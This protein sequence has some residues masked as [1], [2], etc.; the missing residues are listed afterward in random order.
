MSGTGSDA[1][2]RAGGASPARII[3][4]RH[5]RTDANA[6]GLLLGRLDPPLD[7]FGLRQ[8]ERAAQ[9]IRGGSL[10]EVRAVVSSPLLRARQTAEVLGLPVRIDE[11]FVEVDYG[12]YD[13]MPISDVAPETW[14]QWQSDPTFAPPGGESLEVLGQRVRA[15]CEDVASR[16]RDVG[17]VVVVSHV[18]PI[19]A[20]VA[21]ALGIGDIFA[22]R[23]RLDTASLSL[24][25][26]DGG[27]PVLRGFNIVPA[28][29][30][31]A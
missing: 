21:W 26:V 1:T 17:T 2:A 18:S 14:A 6:T 3:L 29:P 13:G 9:L 10:G 24:I 27:R 15:A 7:E 12:D 11:R 4:L 8:A 28:P 22:W 19:K 23:T 5:G 31:G 20:A 16:A 25:D 30:P